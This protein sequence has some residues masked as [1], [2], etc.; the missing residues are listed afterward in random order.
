MVGW[1]YQILGQSTA[2]IT[3][4]LNGASPRYPAS[5]D[6]IDQ[7]TVPF[8]GLSHGAARIRILIYVNQN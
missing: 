8:R 7:L 4:A 1:R 2:S 6:P 3:F 5:I